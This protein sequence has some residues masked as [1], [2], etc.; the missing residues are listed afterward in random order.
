MMAESFWMSPERMAALSA[1][2]G[3]A[4]ED[5]EQAKAHVERHA[6]LTVFGEGVLLDTFGAHNHALALV[7]STLG[8]LVERT[9]YVVDAMGA[10]VLDYQTVDDETSR[11]FTDLATVLGRGTEPL[12]P[13]G[14]A[15]EFPGAPFS[16]V[17]E[18]TV[19]L[20]DPG[21][22]QQQPLWK[23]D[24]ISTDWFNP[25]AYVRETIRTIA[26]RDPFE[27]AVRWLSGDWT[28]FER[29][30]FT[31]VQ[32]GQFSERLGQNLERAAA[33]LPSAW[34]GREAEAAQWYLRRLANATTDFGAFCTQLMGLYRNAVLAAKAFNELASGV[35]ADVVVNAGLAASAMAATRVPHPKVAGA[36][37]VALVALTVRIW[38][39]LRRLDSARD[40]YQKAVQL[41]A[42]TVNT[43]QFTK[44]RQLVVQ[45]SLR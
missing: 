12:G 32:V 20:R 34:R 13:H 15:L 2:I 41:F 44:M 16:D 40:T 26:G 38:Q 43:Y 22:G 7:R 19:V 35:L 33:E 6:A 21:I 30:L 1:Q 24:P 28:A 23:F 39:L 11:V 25:S 9:R 27:D 37:V 3:R 31:W 10:S 4:R 29:V 42:T 17:D 8:E 18:P 5:A 45:D 36:A 14:G